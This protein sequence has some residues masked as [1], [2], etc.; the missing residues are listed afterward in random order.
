MIPFSKFDGQL[1][2]QHSSLVF[3][4]GLAGC[5]VDFAVLV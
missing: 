4:R 1:A 2:W 5:C 3:L